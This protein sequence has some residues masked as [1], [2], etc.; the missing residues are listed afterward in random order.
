MSTIIL[1]FPIWG[2]PLKSPDAKTLS[3]GGSHQQKGLPKPQSLETLVLGFG[4]LGFGGFRVA[5]AGT[6]Q[7]RRPGQGPKATGRNSGL[8]FWC[9]VFEGSPRIWLNSRNASI[10]IICIDLHRASMYTNQLFPAF[11]CVRLL[12]VFC[13]MVTASAFGGYEPKL[14]A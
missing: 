5:P 10:S 14:R 7:M 6:A 8:G 2:L 3:G 12:K 1:E 11:V 13:A 9:G 4:V